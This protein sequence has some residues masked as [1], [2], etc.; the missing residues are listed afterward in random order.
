MHEHIHPRPAVTGIGVILLVLLA[1]T[2]AR[3]AVWRNSLAL[4]E[5]AVA[6]APNKGRVNYQLGREYGM[7]GQRE[8]AFQYMGRSKQ[9]DPT[10][11]NKLLSRAESFRREGKLTEAI[12]E[13][14]R[15]LQQDP[16][17]P[18]VH[19]DLGAVYHERR[20]MVE[21]FLEFSDAIKID[22]SYTMAYANRGVINVEWNALDD[23]VRDYRK[24]VELE[25]GTAN[26]H[27]KLAYALLKQGRT[28]DAIASY[29]TALR[30]DPANERA[31]TER[32]EAMRRWR[33]AGNVVPG[34]GAVK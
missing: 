24:A 27:A 8:K 1:A 14:R 28:G 9:L 29:D 33:A 25:P 19:N 18:V 11:F 22:P 10:L 6:K 5:D 15:I 4:W 31:R 32:E 34:H 21:A 20:M 16:N 2:A 17:Q 12:E 23:A 26:F 3:N 7:A 30:L 13:Y